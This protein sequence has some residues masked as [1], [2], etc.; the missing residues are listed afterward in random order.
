MQMT[1]NRIVLDVNATRNQTAIVAKA[2]DSRSR[3]LD[4]VLTCSGKTITVD[5]NDRAVLMAK[6][7]VTGKTIAA[8]EGTVHNGIIE[9]E[10][11]KELLSVPGILEC[12]VS[13]FGTDSAVLT[14]A[15]FN[16]SV[17]E[18]INTTVVERQAD[19]S[20]LTAAL[21][22]VAQT[23]NRIDEVAERIQPVSLGGTGSTDSVTALRTLKA[24][25]L[26]AATQITENED[27]NDY[28]TPG[29][30]YALRTVA[31]T[32]L[33]CPVEGAFKLFVMEQQPNYYIQLLIA[34]VGNTMWFRGSSS[35]NTYAPWRKVVTTDNVIAESG[36]WVPTAE[37]GTIT[38]G[39]ASYVYDGHLLTLGAKIS[40]GNDITTS[41][42]LS[43]LPIAV[44]YKT[45]G[46][47]ALMDTDEVASVI[48]VDNKL[49]IRSSAAMTGKTII[50]SVTYMI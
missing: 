4:V 15:V 41:L 21:S 40:C 27:L 13:L 19:F 16:I 3:I 10:L 5:N 47:C 34:V 22:D 31:A 35:V 23:A 45:T 12:E 30:F 18:R 1:H 32:L 43:G 29:T 36:S 9:I 38:V 49:K 44:K 48:A 24:A 6:D 25:S 14:S 20:A 28:N 17:L 8:V 33:H 39:T 37:V 2:E 11:S 42:T 7:A 50:I 26:A 46:S